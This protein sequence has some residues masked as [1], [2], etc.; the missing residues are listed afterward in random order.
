MDLAEQRCWKYEVNDEELDQA[1][2]CFKEDLKTG[3]IKL[4]KI[5]FSSVFIKFTK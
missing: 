1:Q 4:L 2:E 5:K 3:E